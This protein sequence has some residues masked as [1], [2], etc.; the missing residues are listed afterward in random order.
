MT[1]REV[2]VGFDPQ[3][4]VAHRRLCC[5]AALCRAV[6]NSAPQPFA[7][8]LQ[9]VHAG[10]ARGRFQVLAGAAVEVE[11]VAALVDQRPGWSVLL[12]QRPFGQLAHRQLAFAGRLRGRPVRRL[13]SSGQGREKP[14]HCRAVRGVPVLFALIQLR[15]AIDRGK[16]VH[17]LAHGL[18]GAQEK[19]AA[20]V[21]R[22]VEQAG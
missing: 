16:K 4:R 2:A 10:L 14:R 5:A 17:E 8:H 22:V 6:V 19:H 1:V 11:D 18:G 20:R 3:A 7:G 15:L 13:A 21:Q 12:Q 9:D